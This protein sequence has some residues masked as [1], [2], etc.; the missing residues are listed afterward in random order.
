MG[1]TSDRSSRTRISLEAGNLYIGRLRT[2]DA[3]ANLKNLTKDKEDEKNDPINDN[4]GE[5]GCNCKKSKC[6]KLYCE[7]FAKGKFCGPYCKCIEC[8][9]H[10]HDTKAREN[11]IKSTLSRNPDA[12]S[13]KIEVLGNMFSNE[14]IIL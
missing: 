14:D 6:L 5:L 4:E 3:Y 13:S 2:G 8:Q 10:E 7:C 1:R 12:F 9:N 11:A